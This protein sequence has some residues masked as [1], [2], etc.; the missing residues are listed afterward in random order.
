M[1]KW[2]IIYCIYTMYMLTRDM[3]A[4]T[5]SNEK[6][7]ESNQEWVIALTFLLLSLFK[8]GIVYLAIRQGF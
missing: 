6:S 1:N 2:F 7:D 3:I 4:Y 8:I 5:K